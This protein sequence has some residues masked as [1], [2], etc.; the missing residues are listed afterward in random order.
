MHNCEKWSPAL[1]QPENSDI[2]T[3]ELP[4]GAVTRLGQGIVERDPAY[5]PC[6]KR[7]V[8]AS[9][10]GVWW[11]NISTMSPLALWDTE[12]GYISAVSFSPN[13]KWLAT[14][15]GDGLVKV[16]DV[17]QGVCISQMERDEAERPYHRVSRLVFSPD[18]GFLAVSS[19]R[20]YILYVWNTE[21]G[22]QIAKFHDNTNYRW[23]PFL[24]RPI[25]FSPDGKFDSV[26]N[27]G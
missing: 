25:A 9:D 22:E 3:W 24:L 20:D 7:L 5:S 23:F 6:G 13:G 12:R 8:F 16:W 15:D 19:Q 18:S 14:G 4:D 1:R 26:Y 10:I 2:T 21:T 17:Q 11:Y 27:A